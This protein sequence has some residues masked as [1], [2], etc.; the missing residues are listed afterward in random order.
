MKRGS[1]GNSTMKLL[2]KAI[3]R[4]RIGSTS[5]ELRCGQRKSSLLCTLINN[6]IPK[7]FRLK[8]DLCDVGMS[9]SFTDSSSAVFVEFSFI[10]WHTTE[11][12][13][14]WSW[15]RLFAWREWTKEKWFH[16]RNGDTGREN[17]SVNSSVFHALVCPAHCTLLSPFSPRHH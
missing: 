1:D 15:R 3:K 11:E 12:C 14:I 2:S 9:V 16:G 7:F 17:R 5:G 8:S 13:H 4:I 10:W 6:E